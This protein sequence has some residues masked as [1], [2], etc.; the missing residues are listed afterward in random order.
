VHRFFA[1]SLGATDETVALDDDEAA[2]LVRVLRIQPGSEVAVFNGR[3][4]E[5]RARV[6]LADKR[7]VVLSVRGSIE[8]A[9]ELPFALVLA[10]AVLRGE[11]MDHVV[12]DAVMLGVT[13]IVPLVTQHAEIGAAQI[14]RTRRVDR[15]ARIAV[16]SA[17]Q[18]GRALVPPVEQPSGLGPLLAGQGAVHVL[19][20]PRAGGAVRHVRDL[21]AAPP[22][23]A[24]V[25]V[26]PEGGWSADELRAAR[27]AGATLVTLGRLTLRA[28]AAAAVALPVLR[29]VWGS[30]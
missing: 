22:A 13:R 1:P 5:R 3:G 27:E 11:G 12:R 19:V 17:K 24:V 18:C 10:Q 2:H 30:L 14:A 4:I 6:A 26:G 25:A 21:P 23:A 16:S 7:G 28:D 20:E 9:P 29:Y 8:P 15:W